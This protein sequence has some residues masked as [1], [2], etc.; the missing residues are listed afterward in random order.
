M[1]NLDLIP[2]QRIRVYDYFQVNIF[3]VLYMINTHLLALILSWD[4]L[5]NDFTLIQ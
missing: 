3:N 4:D 5:D 1:A 2:K